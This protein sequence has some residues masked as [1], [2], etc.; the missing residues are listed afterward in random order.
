MKDYL[1]KQLGAEIR[2]LPQGGRALRR[3]AERAAAKDAKGR[4]W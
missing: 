4:R 2:K 3:A 1:R